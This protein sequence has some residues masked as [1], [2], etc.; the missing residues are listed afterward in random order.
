MKRLLE[1][2]I[3]IKLLALAAIYWFFIRR[4]AG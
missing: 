3:L 1:S 2:A 4:K